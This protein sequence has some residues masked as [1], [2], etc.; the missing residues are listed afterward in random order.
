MDFDHKRLGLG[1]QIAAGGAIA[2]FIFFIFFDWYSVS[3][4][5][6]SAGASGWTAHELLRW[7]VL[8]T[9]I[10]ALAKAF[11]KA[12]DQ[13]VE[14]PVAPGLILTVVAGLTTICVLYR[15]FIDQ[16]GPDKLI[17]LDFGAWLG[18]LSLIA[19]TA[20]GWL[21][22]GEDDGPAMASS[23]PPAAAPTASTAPPPAAPEPPAAA[24]PPA[25]PEPPAAAEPPAA[26]EQPPA[27]EP[28]SAPEPPP[29]T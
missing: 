16:P 18:L 15:M 20:G 29:A 3:I 23:A 17:D 2:L 22:M 26:P 13:S 19:V 10:L 14:L 7:L 27:P 6:F 5:Q 8:L 25:A 12:T 21:S 1:D 4:G 28:P 9:V 11:L 24:E